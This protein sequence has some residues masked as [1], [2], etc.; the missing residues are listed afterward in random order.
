MACH[1]AVAGSMMRWNESARHHGLLPSPEDLY[2]LIECRHADP[3][4]ILG[5]R[6]AE[7]SGCVVRVF[8]PEA[9]SVSVVLADGR[10]LTLTKVHAAGVFESFSEAVLPSGPRDY[11]VEAVFGTGINAAWIDPYA[12]APTLGEVDLYLLG[13]GEHL[14]AY[15][16]LGAHLRTLD[17]IEGTSFAVWAPNAQRVSVVGDFNFWDGRVHMMRRLGD[18]GSGRFSFREWTRGIITSSR[19]ADRT[20]TSFLKR[21]PSAFSPST[22]CAPPA[23]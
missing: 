8:Q 21:I 20:A 17:G 12:F 22:T 5:I 18:L 15:R 11:T 6:P 9:A 13:Q 23:W 3:H 4:R 19:S 16:V 7:V 10:R 14:E 1:A 2:P